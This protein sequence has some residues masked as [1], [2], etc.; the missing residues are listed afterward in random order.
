MSFIFQ[1]MPDRY[2]L[3]RRLKKGHTVAW[4]ASRYRREMKKGDTVYFWRGGDRKYRGIYGWGSIVDDAPSLDNQG[5]YRVRVE[6][7]KNFL[8]H[9]P[10]IFIS[11]D[12][13]AKQSSLQ[14]LLILRVPIGTNFLLTEIQEQTIRSLIARKLDQT[15]APPNPDSDGGEQ[16]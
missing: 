1:G 5:I 11:S 10:P 15:W 14:D 6:Y 16:S 3:R 12:E 13:I 4:V 2:D 8:N 9:D 7:R